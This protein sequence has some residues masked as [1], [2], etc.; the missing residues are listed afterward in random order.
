VGVLN[1]DEC[2]VSDTDSVLLLINKQNRLDESYVP[3]DLIVPNIPFSFRGYNDKKLVRYEVA[4]ALQE[5]FAYANID[6][7]RLYAVSGYRSYNRQKTIFNRNV[8]KYGYE[9]A[10]EFSARAG[11][12][13]HQTGL[14]MDVSSRVV[15]M[16]LVESFG[17]TKEGKWLVDNA[18]KAGFIIRYPKDKMDI[19]G[20]QY[21][22]WHIRYVGLKVAKIIAD[23]DITLEE[24]IQGVI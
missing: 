12:S 5:L 7:V 21:E 4:L 3:R 10:N 13:E 16:E 2:V 1:N 8:N 11:E 18:Y 15:N 6:S 23:N 17:D 9:K 20:Y 14:A 24:Y 22:P 19:T